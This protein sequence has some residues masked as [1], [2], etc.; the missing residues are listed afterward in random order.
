MRSSIV[1]ELIIALDWYSVASLLVSCAILKD[2]VVIKIKPSLSGL[3]WALVSTPVVHLRVSSTPGASLGLFWRARLDISS[4][5][6]SARFFGFILFFFVHADVF[7][8]T[9]FPYQSELLRWRTALWGLDLQRA[10]LGGRCVTV[11]ASLFCSLLA[12][13]LTAVTA[14]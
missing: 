7:W 2:V 6:P 4:P 11:S 10:G 3:W 14:E 13:R 12:L 8:W 5:H 9:L 1:I